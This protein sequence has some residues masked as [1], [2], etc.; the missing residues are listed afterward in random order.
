MEREGGRHRP[1][2]HLHIIRDKHHDCSLVAMVTTVV[3]CRKHSSDV[4]ESEDGGTVT[5]IREAHPL[6]TARNG[7][8][9]LRGNS[10]WRRVCFLSVITYPDKVT[11]LQTC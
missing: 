4:R 1:L 10:Q 7:H 8:Y 11:N 5:S 6:W 3:G 9:Q 2:T